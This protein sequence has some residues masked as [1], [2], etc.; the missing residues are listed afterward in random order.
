[1]ITVADVRTLLGDAYS[2]KPDDPT[3]QNFIDRRKEELQDLIGTDPASAPYQ[4]LLKRWLL[5]KVCCDVLANDL[6]GVDSADVL[7]YS[8]GDLRESKSQNV[9]L[10][11]TWF[12]TFKESAELALNTYFIKTRGYRAVRL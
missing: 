3:I 10:K 9:K 1:M 11:L 2:T 6:L 7:E 4:N 8:I 5:S 12:E